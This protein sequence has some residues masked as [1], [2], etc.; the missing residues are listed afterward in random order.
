MDNQQGN[1]TLFDMA[2]AL[3]FFLGDGSLYTQPKRN[4]WR[5][6]LTKQDKECVERAA[7]QLRKY[8]G[9]AGNLRL[10]TAG[11]AWKF[12]IYSKDLYDFLTLN[13]YMRSRVPQ[14]FFEAPRE[15][16][17]EL[18]AGLFDSDGSVTYTESQ[19]YPRWQLQFTSTERHLVEAVSGLCGQL[20][21]RAN[22]IIEVDTK[23]KRVYHVR[24]N[25]LDFWKAGCVFYSQRKQTRLVEYIKHVHASETL[26]TGACGA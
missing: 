11:V 22:G 9:K 26:Y 15:A 13:T 21:V 14:E 17:I 8:S 3:G 2:Y 7:E 5:V 1:E 10:D 23:H 16:K 6:S 25:M 24:P 19:G 20:R 12:E 4:A 18:L